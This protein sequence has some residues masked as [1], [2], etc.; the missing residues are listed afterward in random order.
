MKIKQFETFT[1][2]YG[3]IKATLVVDGEAFIF[4][5]TFHY[6]E[7]KA[8]RRSGFTSIGKLIY[9]PLW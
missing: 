1:F 6:G 7:I 3:E 9:I 4:L 5:F 2:H 8:A